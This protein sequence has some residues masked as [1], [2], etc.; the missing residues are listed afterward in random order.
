[1]TATSNDPVSRWKARPIVAA[2]L[3]ALAGGSP[4]IVGYVV[5]SI[6]AATLQPLDRL[7]W[8][9]AVPGSAVVAGWLTIL[10]TA[11]LR[12]L[13]MLYELEL[14]FPGWAPER[15]EVVKEAARDPIHMRRKMAGASMGRDQNLD[16]AAA[17]VLAM[18]ITLP[19]HDRRASGHPHRVADYSD[20]IAR[21][22]RIEDGDRE[23]IKWA[24]LSHGLGKLLLD[25][26]LLAE[27]GDLTPEEQESW[28]TYPTRGMRLI[29]PMAAWLG[30]S[31]QAVESHAENWDGSGFPDHKSGDQIPLPARIVAVAASLDV[32][33]T[34]SGAV[35]HDQARRLIA[36]ASATDFDPVVVR[37]FLQVPARTL[38]AASGS[39]SRLIP[40]RAVA[41]MGRSGPV[42]ALSAAF[43][44][45]TAA[46][47]GGALLPLPDLTTIDLTAVLGLVISEEESPTTT[48]LPGTTE[49]TAPA[50]TTSTGGESTTT[51]E[52]EVTSTS[53][54]RR[55][56]TTSPGTT[57]TP[58]TTNT[59]TTIPGTT[60]TSTF[61]TTTTTSPPTTTTTEDPPTTTTTTEPPTTT[62][63]EPPTTTTTEPPT[64]TTTEPPTTTTTADP[65][66]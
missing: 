42:L 60:S 20:L 61:A 11:R 45:T 46:S 35:S 3:R 25:R 33:T 37:A 55:P 54:P 2:F 43:L 31:A 44:V 8:W 21:Q 38:K 65:G 22:L 36:A 15:W 14:I 5:A 49:E 6:I 32:L 62:T 34:G 10:A 19:R 24:A 63:T 7:P 1:M 53:G 66:P 51:S 29:G 13:A 28:E 17:A 26:D 18:A 9:L 30:S 41:F 48:T 39:L 40:E 56:T 47:V 50:A 59:T 27:P 23:R 52:A 16:S 4:I 64:T 57:T 58:G 12:L